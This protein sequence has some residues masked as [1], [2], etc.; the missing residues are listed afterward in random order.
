MMVPVRL[1][2]MSWFLERESS[3]CVGTCKNTWN[4]NEKK[5]FNSTL[6]CT[7]TTGVKYSLIIVWDECFLIFFFSLLFP[8]FYL[9]FFTPSFYFN[10]LFEWMCNV[11][12]LLSLNGNNQ[13][14]NFISLLIIKA[15]PCNKHELKSTR[16]FN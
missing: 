9:T 6:S 8:C 12:C 15:Y 7:Y 5:N 11:W 1:S 3:E 13:Q 2:D 14:F 10:V 16:W 4:K